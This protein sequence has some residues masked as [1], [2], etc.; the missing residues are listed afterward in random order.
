MSNRLKFEAVKAFLAEVAPVAASPAAPRAVVKGKKPKTERLADHEM[1]MADCAWYREAPVK[2]AATTPY[3]DWFAGAS[4]TARCENGEAIFHDY[5]AK[6][7]KYA[8]NDAAKMLEQVSGENSGPRTCASIR[9]DLGHEAY[10]AACPHWG[11]ITSPIQLGHKGSRPYA[12]SDI[13]PI[14]LGYSGSEF[15]FRNQQTNQVVR[16]SANQLMTIPGLLDMAPLH[17]WKTS[18]SEDDKIN[19]ASVC[20]ALVQAGRAKGPLNTSKIRGAG[21]WQEGNR[22]IVNLGTVRIDSDGYIYTS[23]TEPFKLS[24]DDPPTDALFEFLSVFNWRLKSAPALLFGWAV[25]AAICGALRWRPHMAITGPSKAG[26]TTSWEAIKQALNPMAIVF[27]GASTE[28]GI[29]QSIGASARPVLLDECDA[30]TRADLA[31]AERVLKLMRSASSAAANVARGTPEGKAFSFSVNASF[32][33]AGVNI[34]TGGVADTSRMVRLELNPPDEP[35]R[36]RA[37]LARFQGEIQ[38]LGPAFCNLAI[39]HASD[40]LA[41]IE[42]IKGA[43]VGV[44]ARQA[45]NFATLL[46]G[47]FVGI[48][49]RVISANEAQA[50]VAEHRD[51]IEAHADAQEEDD[52]QECLNTLLGFICRVELGGVYVNKSLGQLLGD[53]LGGANALEPRIEVLG[54]HGIQVK[55]NTVLVSTNHSQLNRVFQ[56]S[57]WAGQLWT[58]ALRRLPGATAGEGRTFADGTRSR[59]TILPKALIAVRRE[60]A[61]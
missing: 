41:S 9:N 29:R 55:G 30:K 53:V 12:P 34:Y 36:S 49:R 37:E 57:V 50:L 45:D 44:D 39:K 11:K 31:N 33:V 28:A 25:T 6:H 27:D 23:P 58:G 13:G 24:P 4:I 32:L 14:P 7:P 48:N 51:A 22:I 43:M 42:S 2:G 16:K 52:A 21:V 38:G 19:L 61:C 15:I 59:V 18:F 46:A 26:K 17:F 1:I 3:P 5:S 35:E 56:S 8:H 40:I 54:Q 20:D 10:C 47:Y 60:E